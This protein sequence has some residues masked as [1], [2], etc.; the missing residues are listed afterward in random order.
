MKHYEIGM[1]IGELSLGAGFDGVLPGAGSTTAPSCG[2]CTAT[3]R[4]SGA[5]ARRVRP[6]RSSSACCGST[7][8]T[9]KAS[10]PTSTGFAKDAHGRIQSIDGK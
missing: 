10:A 2:A 8:P 6:P 9:T 4:V 7:H 5:S 1:R 3:A